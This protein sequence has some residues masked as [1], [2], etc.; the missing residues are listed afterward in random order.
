MALIGRKLVLQD[1]ADSSGLP[2]VALVK[3]VVKPVSKDLE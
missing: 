3:A 1:T 2:F